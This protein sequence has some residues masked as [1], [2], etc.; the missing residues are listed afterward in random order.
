LNLRK[1]LE[2]QVLGWAENPELLLVR[3]AFWPAFSTKLPAAPFL[4]N[5]FVQQDTA[6]GRAQSEWQKL[7]TTDCTS[8]RQRAVDGRHV[9]EALEIICGRMALTLKAGECT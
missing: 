7:G 1:P 8:L 2:P 9:I 4:K 5:V 6:F 3:A